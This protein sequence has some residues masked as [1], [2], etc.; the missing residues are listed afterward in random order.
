MKTAISALLLAVIA[1]AQTNASATPIPASFVSAGDDREAIQAL[2]DTYTTAVS[3]KNEALFETILVNKDIPFTD[4]Q[5][6]IRASGAQRGT[7]HYESFRKGVFEG[8]AFTQRFENVH[9]EQ[10]GPLAAVSLVF[11]NSSAKGSSWGWKT[12]QLLKVSGQWKI[13]SEFFTGHA[14]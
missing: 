1:P 7:E 5:S 10:D 3:T 13:A 14:G 11:V 6:A 4:V 9:V 2:L 12:L 8:P